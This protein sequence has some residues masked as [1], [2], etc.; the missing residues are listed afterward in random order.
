MTV[1][2]ALPKAYF[3]FQHQDGREDK[4]N[5]AYIVFTPTKSTS[6]IREVVQH[7]THS[8]ANA[9]W[10]VRTNNLM[11]LPFSQ[12]GSSDDT[13]EELLHVLDCDTLVLVFPVVW[14]SV[15]ATLKQWIEMVFCDHLTDRNMLANSQGCMQGKKVIVVAV[16]EEVECMRR[17]DSMEVA[18]AD[19]LRPLLEGTLNYLGFDV[20]RPLFINGMDRRQ[21]TETNELLH[22]V[23]AVFSQLERRSHFY[24]LLRPAPGPS[25]LS[26]F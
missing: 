12:I 15:P 18:M 25:H 8:L 16:S 9:G 24:G 6:L 22:E 5:K 1:Y 26:M 3:L 13:D 23:T 20:L 4:M 11:C 14:S 19:M 17:G 7:A 21:A 10:S 2:P